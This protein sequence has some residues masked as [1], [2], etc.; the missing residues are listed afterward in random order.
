MGVGLGLAII[1]LMGRISYLV[2]YPL[3]Y[4]VE[5]SLDKAS[6]ITTTLLLFGYSI[7]FAQILIVPHFSEAG[8][9]ISYVMGVMLA[10]NI[11]LTLNP[12]GRTES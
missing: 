2:F 10:A 3:G 9:I 7:M 4:G 1:W 6:A 8:W 11:V 12:I 5:S